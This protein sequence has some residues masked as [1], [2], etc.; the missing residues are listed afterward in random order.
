MVALTQT[1]I[2]AVDVA[3][4]I[5]LVAMTIYH[6]TWD[7]EFFG[8]IAPGTT[9]E[10]GWVLFARSIAVTFV[11]LVGV[12]LVLGHGTAIHWCPFSRR[13]AMVAG[14]AALVTLSTWWMTPQAYVFFGVLHAIALFSLLGL[15]FARLPW[16]CAAAAALA[17][18]ATN[19]IVADDLFSGALYWT[20]LHAT[21]PLSNDYVP[22][23]PWFAA[24][25]AGIAVTKLARAS[26]LWARVTR[27]RETTAIERPFVFL[28]RHSLVYYLLHQPAMI[29]ALSLAA[30]LGVKP[31]PARHFERSCTLQCEETGDGEICRRFCGCV[32]RSL[33]GQG[34]L[35]G[36]AAGE[37][38]EAAGARAD[39]LIMQC[40]SG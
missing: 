28:G 26:P 8:W 10:I 37:L 13:W 21:N 11:F 29:G 16:W 34:L 5:A 2:A 39:G 18:V 19:A 9:A 32:T 30:T 38:D 22:L 27:P 31:D 7:L 14:A 36:F 6:F 25:L 1:R 4:G 15:P 3:R 12:G 33:A 35:D 40:R 20:G 17:V 24:T 23:F